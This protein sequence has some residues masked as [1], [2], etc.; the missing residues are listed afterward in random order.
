[1]REFTSQAVSR[2]EKLQTR[3]EAAAQGARRSQ[4]EAEYNALVRA[5]AEQMVDLGCEVK[6]LWLLDFD[7][8]D[9]IYYCWRHPEPKLEYF[10]DYDSGFAGRKPLGRLAV[11]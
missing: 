10:H 3:I 7:S 5:W 2:A 9:G 4:L 11:H 8:G 1:M 6:G